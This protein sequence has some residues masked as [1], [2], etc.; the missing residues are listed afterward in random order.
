MLATQALAAPAAPAGE[1]SRLMGELMSFG[2]V[3]I[4]GDEAVSGATVFPG[5]RFATSKESGAIVNLGAMGRVRFASETSGLINFDE[6]G[7]QGTLE[8][9]AM[10]VSKAQGVAAVFSTQ[11][12]QVVPAVGSAAIFTVALKDGK[13]VVKT[14]VGSVELRSGKTTKVVGAGQTGTAGTT[15]NDDDDDDTDGLFWLG[16]AG[17]TGLVV[18]AIIWSLNDDDNGGGSTT[19]IVVVPSPS[20]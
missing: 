14:E 19:P 6:Q 10:T 5:S 20:R 16:V 7:L 9:G 12:A 2:H 17:F 4:N 18:G 1:R 8:G 3:L 15:T 11:D 13:T